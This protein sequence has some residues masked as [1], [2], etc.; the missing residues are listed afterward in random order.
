MTGAI[1]QGLSGYGFSLMGRSHE[2]SK[3]PCQDSH[4]LDFCGAWQI[5]AVADGVGSAAYS[6]LGSRAVVDAAVDSLMSDLLISLDFDSARAAICKAFKEALKTVEILAE[7]SKKP[8]EDYDT[9][10]TLCIY[11]GKR[12]FYGQ[13]GDGGVIITD[14]SGYYR[15]ITEV[16]KGE[17][18]NE[19]YPLRAGEKH[20]AFGEAQCECQSLLLVTDGLLDVIAPP[21]LAN[22]QE[23]L[24]RKMA[25]L[26]LPFKAP[27]S[28]ESFE[29]EL[30]GIVSSDRFLSLTDD[31][32]AVAVWRQAA[33]AL[34]PETDYLKEPD[35]EAL[36]AERYYKLY[37]HLR[38]KEEDCGHTEKEET[39]DA[40]EHCERENQNS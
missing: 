22:E 6:D 11:D 37:P 21:L 5:A 20:W 40:G 23:R 29:Q 27:K 30:C 28:C 4:R 10:L 2:K 19:V 36:K 12:V 15:L 33:Q 17:A 16:Q 3:V 35:W 1:K 39:P 8:L 7:S 14:E 25:N 32:S 18:Y 24:Y 38:P 34:A 13:S 31:L 9:T 26:F